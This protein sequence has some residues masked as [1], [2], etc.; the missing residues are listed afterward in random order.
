MTL[1]IID[2]TTRE[3]M[4]QG[5]KEKHSQV[6]RPLHTDF[7]NNDEKQGYRVTFVDGVDD[8]NNAPELVAQREADKIEQIRTDELLVKIDESIINPDEIKEFLKLKFVKGR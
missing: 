1:E 4:K 3:F 6:L 5:K 2:Y 8:P 7:V